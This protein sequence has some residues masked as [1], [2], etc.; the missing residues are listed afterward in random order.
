MYFPTNEATILSL[1]K[2]Y[3]R[4]MRLTTFVDAQEACIH[5]LFHRFLLHERSNHPLLVPPLRS[6]FGLMRKSVLEK[7]MHYIHTTLRTNLYYP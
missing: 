1:Y 3:F 4:D 5:S 2:D 7:Y 6:V